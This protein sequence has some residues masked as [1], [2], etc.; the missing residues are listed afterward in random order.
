MRKQRLLARRLGTS[1]YYRVRDL[2]TFRLLDVRAR[3]LHR[4]SETQ[5]VCWMTSASA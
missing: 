5:A 1:L 2:R 4:S 3:S